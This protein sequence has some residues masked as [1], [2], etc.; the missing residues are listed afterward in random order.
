[1]NSYGTLCLF[2]LIGYD[3]NEAHRASGETTD[4]SVNF[5]TRKMKISKGNF[6][7]DAPDS[8]VWKTFKLK[9]LFTIESIRKPFEMEFEGIYL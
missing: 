7:N 5:I 6:A 8:V 3:S 9:K 2:V 1:M 4:Y